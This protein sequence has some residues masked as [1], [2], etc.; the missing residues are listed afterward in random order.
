MGWFQHRSSNAEHALQIY[1][2][3]DPNNALFVTT[4]WIIVIEEFQHL[5]D[6]DLVILMKESM[7]NATV[8]DGYRVGGVNMDNCEFHFYTHIPLPSLPPCLSRG[9]LSRGRNVGE[10][11]FRSLHLNHP[12]HAYHHGFRSGSNCAA[13]VSDL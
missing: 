9:V 3:Y 10:S 12:S 8:G 11:E 7:Y 2:S 4:S 13:S 5:L 6:P 1:D